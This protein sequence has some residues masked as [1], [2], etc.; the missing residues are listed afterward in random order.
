[1]PRNEIVQCTFMNSALGKW[2]F[3]VI[4]LGKCAHC[5][6]TENKS[7]ILFCSYVLQNSSLESARKH[8][9]VKKQSH[10]ILADIGEG[11]E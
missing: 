3:H 10:A 11:G 7:F 1:M 2:I 6:R 9:V 8:E 5:V 4:F